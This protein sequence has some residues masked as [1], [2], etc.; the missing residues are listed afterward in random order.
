LRVLGTASK[1]AAADTPANIIRASH[2]Y[3]LVASHHSV[4]QFVRYLLVDIILSSL[5]IIKNSLPRPRRS[6]SLL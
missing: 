5:P 4:S 3:L 6:N 1:V 2:V